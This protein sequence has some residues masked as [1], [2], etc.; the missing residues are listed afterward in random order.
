MNGHNT[1]C[2]AVSMRIRELSHSVYQTQYHIVWGTKY[3]R[4]LLKHYV[5][6]ELIKS[7]YK[8]QRKHPT[9]YFVEI[10]TDC[11]HVHLLMEIP[12][13]DRLSDVVRE[14]KV[15]SSSHLRKSFKFI[16][17][18]YKESGIWSVGYFVSTVGLNEKTIR[19][20]I[21]L[22]NAKDIGRD[23]SEEFS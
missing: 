20:Y 8:T 16:D 6:K 13:S 17:R 9:W 10:N 23:I 19:K 14:L 7:L 1:Q 22:Q 2:Y 12:P 4:K 15:D 21:F 11:D 18:I 5:R 3:R